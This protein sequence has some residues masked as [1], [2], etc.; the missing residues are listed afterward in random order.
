MKFLWFELHCIF[1]IIVGIMV[2]LSL[3]VAPETARSDVVVDV[4]FW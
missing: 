4:F 1:H 3:G 2:A